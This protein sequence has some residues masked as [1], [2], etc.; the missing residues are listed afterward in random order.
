MADLWNKLVREGDTLTFPWKSDLLG[1]PREILDADTL[2]ADFDPTRGTVEG[3]TR[4]LAGEYMKLCLKSSHLRPNHV[5]TEFTDRQLAAK[6]IRLHRTAREAETDHGVTTLFAAIGFLRWYEKDDAAEEILSPLLLVPVKLDRD[7]IESPFTLAAVEDEVLPNHCLAELLQSQFKIR[8]PTPTEH[9]IDLENPA[10]LPGYLEAVSARIKDSPRWKIV[11]DTALGVF[12]FQ[13]LAIWEDLGRNAERIKAHP[14]CRAVAGAADALHPTSES[15]PV[16]AELDQVVPPEKT[17]HI[18]DADSS[19]HE[20]IE[21]VKRGADV[22]MEGPPGTGKSQT[23]ANMIAETLAAGK[24]VLFVSEKTAALEVVKR[25]LD[26]CGL[27]DF[28]LELHSHKASKKEVVSELGRCLA[29]TAEGA[30]NAAAALRELGEKRSE[31]NDY[32]RELHA[33][34]QPLGWSAFRVHGELARID[35]DAGRSRIAIPDAFARD[36][37]YVRRGTE[38]LTAL[39]DCGS[40][41]DEPGGHPWHGCKLTTVSHS[42]RDDAAY[43]LQQLAAA[44]PAAQK[45]VEGLA[46]AGLGTA[47]FNVPGW[48]AA[49]AD[50]KKLLA[51]PVFPL[52]WFASDAGTAARAVIDLDAASRQAREL[53]ARLPEFDPA[54][55]RKITSPAGVQ[56]APERERLL[57]AGTLSARER[58]TVLARLGPALLTLAGDSRAIDEQGRDIAS[59]LLLPAPP[60]FSRMGEL[61]QL[62]IRLAR[63]PAIPPGCWDDHRR[64]ELIAAA[65][66][67]G[68]ESRAAREQR[69]G[70]V[71]K[72]TPAALTAESATLAREAAAAANSFWRWLPWSRWA[73]L[74]KQ[75]V[76]W[77]PGGPPADMRKD[78]AELAL[79]HQ[80][81]S[82][83]EQVRAAYYSDLVKNAQGEPDWAATAVM[84]QDV[85]RL[86]KWKASADLAPRLGP[87]GKL[88]RQSL[89]R[90]AERL[91]AGVEAFA[92]QWAAVVRDLAVNDP[93][94]VLDRPNAEVA[95]WMDAE[96]AAAQ[97]EEAVLARIVE[98]LATGKD[99]PAG[100]I[101]GQT[102]FLASLIT[103]R[104]SISRAALTLKESRAIESLEAIDHAAAAGKATALLAF[105]TDWGRPL[106][107]PVA[108]ALTSEQERQR[109]AGLLRDSTDAHGSFDKSWKRITDELFDPDQVV[110]RNVALNRVPLAELGKWSAARAGDIDRL[111]EWCRFLQVEKD[112]AA[113]GIGGI[114]DEVKAGEYPPA[115]A[116]TAFRAR[117]YRLWLDG[118]YQKVPILGSF[119]TE[120]HERLVSRFAE[121]DRLVI[122]STPR[123]VR[124]QLLSNPARPARRET[125]PE[126]SEL[127]IL[128]HEA[129]KKRRHL[130]LRTL[131]ARIPWILPR[132]KP[133]LMM[134]PLA[135]ST[136]L[137]TSEITFD[138]VIFDE[139]SQVRPHDAICAIYRGRQLVVGG[140]PKQLPPT[141]FFSRGEDDGDES[142]DEGTSSFESLLDV[143]LTGKLARKSLRWHYRSRR[144]GL[145]AFSNRHFY[146]GRL[147]TF[148]SADEAMSPAIAF[149][150]VEGAVF[151]DGVNV[152]EAKRVAELVMEHA[153]SK[154][155]QSL[156]VI[157]FS[158]RQQARILDE[159]EVLRR[160][161]P[162]TEGFF[163]ASREDPFFVKNLENVQGDE[164]DIILLDVGYGPDAAGKVAMRFGPLNRQGGERRL[165]VA[166][167]RAR[168][169]MTVVSSLTAADIDL[170]RTGAEGAKLLRAFLDYAQRGT[171]ALDRLPEEASPELDAV[172]ER[173]VADELVRRGLSI[174][175]QVGC[176]GYLIDV[177]VSDPQQGGRYLLGVECDGFT[178]RTAAT[179]R[180]RDRLR[181]TVLEGLGWRLIR[182]WSSD[183]ARDR[184]K[185]VQRVLEALKEGPPARAAAAEPELEMAPVVK[186]KAPKA[187]EYEEIEAVPEK[188]IHDAIQ[189]ALSEYGS[190][191]AEELVTAVSKRLGFKRT[192]PKIRER[193][194][195]VVNALA[196]TGTLRIGD[197][198]RVRYT[199][200][201]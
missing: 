167:T 84:L 106:T 181:Q 50:W 138:L 80:R 26:R 148:P 182:V 125:A 129:H 193:I 152:V 43:S 39:A 165:N 158:Q 10:C 117:F 8:L 141:D 178:Y 116:G 57:A 47:P 76:A 32:V 144:E 137:D 73:K 16:A 86:T 62:G 175:R 173:E 87:A 56:Y 67:A 123:R 149:V 93:G 1:V 65:G 107:P 161:S 102:A 142:D 198:T 5:L 45:A 88:D 188:A 105:L 108:A 128:L 30:P 9:P 153:R 42:V 63:G 157:A 14:L 180:D 2:A 187:A 25:R 143:C 186:W 90:A 13:K 59:Q 54:A 98:L 99:I 147:I 85:D 101:K 151:K 156:G 174:Q 21:A 118:L 110:S 169:G 126:T 164:R 120:A 61:A 113:F 136:Y 135:V 35:R 133:C 195:G 7:T 46:S 41:I 139:A 15:L 192:G 160:Q 40:V 95:A 79:Y 89:L 29:I 68:E 159:L 109:V 100:A 134:S 4:D 132:L 168:R 190:M 77:Y 121:L 111:G 69:P 127:G 197:E 155:E 194:T 191:P 60:P 58:L 38:I 170:S 6:L 131:F 177:A 154:P 104:E 103:A 3:N 33:V 201:G 189:A 17:T 78:V 94:Q 70:L 18:L 24:T 22:V 44:V 112:A 55:V 37:E 64:A 199:K 34:R 183:W 49:E 140:D 176:G 52:D 146:E 163:A 200:P 75:V 23:I 96:A 119:A 20:A 12:N 171:A 19:Q 11:E 184:E 172:L 71:A 130:P 166:I 27:G 145:I 51:A 185:Q 92:G 196:T 97:Q 74:R 150:K 91:A 179:A 66:R 115:A 72:F 48:R 31:L 114:V 122:R 36:A 82:A 162:A 53:F 28:C 124:S 83:A 81:I